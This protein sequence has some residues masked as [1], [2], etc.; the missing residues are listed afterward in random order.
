MKN[1]QSIIMELYVYI[2]I[3]QPVENT[4]YAQRFFGGEYPFTFIVK[5]LKR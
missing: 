1:E 5:H 2:N 3:V 4:P